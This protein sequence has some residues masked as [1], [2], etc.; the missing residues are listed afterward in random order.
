[1]MTVCPTV[2]VLAAVMVTVP[3]LVFAQVAAV[4]F[5]ASV[6]REAVA[7]AVSGSVNVNPVGLP[8][9]SF[10]GADTNVPGLL[11]IA[12]VKVVAVADVTVQAPLSPPGFT[13]VTVTVWPTTELLF[14]VNVA[15]PLAHVAPV[16][17]DVAVP[18]KPETINVPL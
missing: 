7:R 16:I 18:V 11:G 4:I 13:P 15:W 2:N 17:V 8:T 9:A 3:P 1:M 10:A 6:A 14:G 5:T 12:T